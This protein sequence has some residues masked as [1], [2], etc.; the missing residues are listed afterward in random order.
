MIRTVYQ[1]SRQTI[2]TDTT[3]V[4]FAFLMT[5]CRTLVLF[6]MVINNISIRVSYVTNDQV[7]VT[8]MMIQQA[9]EL[10][11]TSIWWLLIAV[12]VI[13]LLGYGL[14][15]PIGEASMIAYLDQSWDSKS[16]LKAFG[17]WSARFFPM[18]EFASLNLWFSFLTW[19][20]AIG[21]LYVTWVL[22]SVLI[23]WFL[24]I[25]AITILCMYRARAYVKILIVT[26][27]MSV[28]DAISASIVLSGAN[29]WQTIKAIIIGYFL[30]VRFLLN[31]C[32]VLLFMIGIAYGIVVYG[33]IESARVTTLVYIIF[34][35]MLIAV[36]YINA[37]I[38]AFFMTYRYHVYK[39]IS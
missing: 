7:S 14:L 38:E 17:I 1:Q 27:N 2:A 23:I 32:I 31:L 9:F 19:T 10:V 3:Y 21:R 20:F 18:F 11:S 39:S 37:I 6:F 8:N 15:Y 16:S 35:G 34:F 29:V 4:S 28:G 33:L 26:K 5:I 36:S 24:I 25:W 22:D 12:T 13:V 30:Q